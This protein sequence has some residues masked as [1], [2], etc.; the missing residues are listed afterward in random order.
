MD[1]GFLA[2][3]ESIEKHLEKTLCAK[4]NLYRFRLGRPCATP[5]AISEMERLEIMPG[6]LLLRHVTLDQGSLDD[7]DQDHN[8]YAAQTKGDDRER[9]FSAF[10]IAD[11][12]FWVI[13]EADRSVTTILL[14]SEY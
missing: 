6:A 11:A 9:V 1:D 8:V 12:K 3:C 10:T 7:E 14:P 2:S 5:G 4:Q 13:T